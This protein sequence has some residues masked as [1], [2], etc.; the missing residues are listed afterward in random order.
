MYFSRLQ[1]NSRRREARKL[2]ANPRAMHAAVESSFP[3]V[4][5][6]PAKERVLW[7]VDETGSGATL[8]VVSPRKPDM[9]HIVEAAGWDTSPSES[10]AYGKFLDRIENGQ[11]YQFRV[12]VNPV[13]RLRV[14]GGRGKLVPH[15]T[16]A[17]QLDWFYARQDRWGFKVLATAEGE[18][19]P[20][21]KVVKRADRAFSKGASDRTTRVTQRHVTIVG[22]LEVVDADLLRLSLIEGLGRGK[23]YGCGLMTL[24]RK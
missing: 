2:L 8:Y 19:S 10:L 24:S 16:E 21:A 14:Q 18:D 15:V 1:I 12:T 22:D 6:T 5:G 4:D 11:E 20:L 13:K 7:R 3:P 23:A 9:A 17:Q